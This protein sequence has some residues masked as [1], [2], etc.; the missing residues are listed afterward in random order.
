[1]Q[2]PSCRF[3]NMPGLDACGRCG[4]HLRLATAVLDVEPPRATPWQ[5]RLRRWLPWHRVNRLRYAAR[6]GRASAAEFLDEAGYRMPGWS[7]LLRLAIPGWVHFLSGQTTRGRIFLG[8]FLGLVGSG[9]LFWGTVLGS[10]LLGLAFSV[11][12]SSVFDILC[13]RPASIVSRIVAGAA[14]LL[15]LGFAVYMPAN[16]LL[17]RV[18][19]PVGVQLN[20]PLFKDGD[21]LLV[22]AWS[23]PKVGSLALY[24]RPVG[25]VV[26]VRFY[27]GQW[28]DRILAGPGDSV[29][30]L[31]GQLFVNGQPSA[32]LPLNPSQLP[33]RIEIAEVPSDHFL[34][35]PTAVELG[36]NALRALWG[37][38]PNWRAMSLVRAD[39]I[40]GTVYFRNQPL[41][42]FG[43][44]H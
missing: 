30:W 24:A 23:T 37:Q 15:V 19:M 11:H 21:V 12:A 5:K 42:R 22:N 2:C 14:V 18:A 4:S 6:E 17:N 40:Q 3:E 41:T 35:F 1:M 43:P 31:N 38:D 9:A 20:T 26:G 39:S 13:Q 32:L 16:W 10:V 36:G 44:L 29:L 7:K 33:A 25:N 8:A 27:A 34:I 28:I